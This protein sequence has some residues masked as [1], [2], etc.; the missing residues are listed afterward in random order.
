MPEDPDTILHQGRFLTFRKKLGND[1][2]YVTRHGPKGSVGILAVTDQREFLVVEQFRPPV[3]RNTLE[4]PA[5]LA[6]DDPYKADEPLISAAR[7]ELYEETGYEAKN[8][9]SLMDGA[10]SPGVTDEVVTMFLATGLRK[11]ADREVHGVGGEEIKLH[12][13][14]IGEALDFFRKRRDEGVLIDFKIY[15]ALY[16]GQR[17]K[18]FPA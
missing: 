7:R 5:G 8:W 11:V 12:V 6:G 14:R 17:H 2:E 4:L 16:A 10:S 9:W 13:V 3:G 15:A 18:M 1:W